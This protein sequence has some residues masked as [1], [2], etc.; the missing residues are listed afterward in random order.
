MS[1]SPTYVRIAASAGALAATLTGLALVPAPADP[2]PTTASADLL[3]AEPVPAPEPTALPDPILDP[4]LEP[5]RGRPADAER[6]RPAPGAFA[7]E[8]GGEA[9]AYETMAVLVLPGA[10]TG[11]LVPDAT[12]AEA[13]YR[14]LHGAGAARSEGPG[15]WVWTAPDEPGIHAL[16]IEEVGAAG[17]SVH[18]NALVAHPRSHVQDEVLHGYRIGRYRETPLRGDPAYRPPEAFVEVAPEDENVLVA[19]HFTLG[20]FLCKQPGEPRFVSL[21]L[22]LLR[23]LEAVL[24]ATNEAGVQTP[25]F[26]VMS[27]FRTPAYNRAIG[28]TTDYSRHLWGDAADIFVDV[29]GDGDMDDLNGDGRSDLADARVLYRIVEGIERERSGEVEAGGLGLYRRNAAHGPFVHVDARGAPA[30]W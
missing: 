12:E 26:H 18:V 22:P 23:K 30:R 20:Q 11:I 28:N 25:T 8:V 15:R 2:T 17:A 19:P 3:P 29:D 5:V 9:V 13:G 7:V 16:R 10:E 14:L 24:E 1:R 4:T 6:Y 27:G 21:T